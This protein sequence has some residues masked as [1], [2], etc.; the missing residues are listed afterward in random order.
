MKRLIFLL[1]ITLGISQLY[2]TEPEHKGTKPDHSSWIK[3]TIT[4]Q[5]TGEALVGVSLKLKGSDKKVYTDLQGVFIIENV[6]PG[7][8]DIDI[9]YVSYKEVTLKEVSSSSMATTL[10]VE[11]ESLASSF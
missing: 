3:G 5:I 7:K 11:L 2:A 6:P 8:Y 4:D 1:V 10:K 9:A